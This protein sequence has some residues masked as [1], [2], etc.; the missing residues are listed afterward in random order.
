MT[1]Y[2]FATEQAKELVD[3]RWMIYSYGQ[4]DMAAMT[5]TSIDLAKV[6]GYASA[7]VSVTPTMD[8][9]NTYW[10]F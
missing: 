7:F 3:V 5:R 1:E 9:S 10:P 8:S 6:T 4:L 2:T